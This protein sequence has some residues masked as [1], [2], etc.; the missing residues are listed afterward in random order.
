MLA[1]LKQRTVIIGNAGSGKSVFAKSLAASI[2]APVIDLYTL[3][4]Q[5]NGYGPKRDEAS[6]THL[7]RDAAAAPRWIIEGVYGWLAEVA[8]PRATALVWL[9]L[10]WPLCLEGLSARGQQRGGT[11]EDFA[12]LLRWAEA[13]WHRQTSSSFAGHLRLFTNF[14]GTKARLHDREQISHLLAQLSAATG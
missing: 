4:W 6:A 11:E 3:H 7:V 2:D 12:D 14:A 9:D 10:P 1:G 5:D 13:Y 8:M